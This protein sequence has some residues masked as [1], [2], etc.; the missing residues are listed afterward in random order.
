MSR[1]GFNI[2]GSKKGKGS[3][4]D[5]IQFLRGFEDIIIHPRCRGAI[6]NFT[7]YKWKQDRISQEVLPIPA[8]GSDHWPDAARYAL[9]DFIKNKEANIRWL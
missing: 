7:N 8:D 6:D 3:V 4:E 9:E 2:R 5:G 1:K